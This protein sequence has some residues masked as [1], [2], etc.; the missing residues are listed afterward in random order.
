[1][2]GIFLMM[3]MRSCLVYSSLSM[4]WLLKIGFHIDRGHARDQVHPCFPQTSS[5]PINGVL[6]RCA[7]KVFVKDLSI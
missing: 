5:V 2:P 1:M 4:L 6:S 7:I 3:Y